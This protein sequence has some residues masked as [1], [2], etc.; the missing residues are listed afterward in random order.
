MALLGEMFKFENP[1]NYV[2]GIGVLNLFEATR[3]ICR[4]QIPVYTS[5]SL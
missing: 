3:S 2:Q 4:P 5:V 1:G